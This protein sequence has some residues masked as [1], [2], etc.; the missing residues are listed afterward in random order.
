MTVQEKW[1]QD[2]PGCKT[3]VHFNNAGAALMPQPVISAIESHIRLE[4]EIGGYEA[5]EQQSNEVNK[6]YSAA[7]KLIGAKPQQIAFTSSATNSFARALS[8]VPFNTGDKVLIAN[9]DYVSNQLAFLSVKKRFG[10]E[11]LRA[12]SL[13]EGGIDPDAF[14][15]LADKHR[16]VLASIT[17]VPTNSGLVQPVGEIGK[18]CRSLDIP[19]LLDACQSAGQLPLDV[20][21]TYCDFLSAT[22]RK[23]LRGPRGAGFLYVSDRILNKNWY[24]LFIDM[25]GAEWT[26]ENEFKMQPDASRFEDWELPYALQMGS[27]AA[28]DYALQTGIKTIQDRNK[29][30]MDYLKKKITGKG[31]IPLDRGNETCSILTVHFNGIDPSV[32][33]NKLKSLHINTSVSRNMYA[34]IDFKSKNVDWALRISPHYY[35]TEQEIDQLTEALEN[36]TSA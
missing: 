7:G 4:S 34:R 21:E 18:I 36:L 29:I 9:E 25:K 28:L 15:K 13:P 16:P 23:F 5:Y 2:T 22:M 32:L 11:L 10:I 27:A 33:H 17:H 6:F 8:S 24:P 20:E 14:R 12:P 19:F 3:S 30:L 35:N 26:E 1:R 31:W